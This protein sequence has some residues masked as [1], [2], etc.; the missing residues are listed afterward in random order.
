MPAKT[1]I[2]SLKSTFARHGI[3]K[4]LYTESGPQFTACEFKD[5][6]KEWGFEHKITSPKHRQ[7]NGV[8]ERHIQTLKRILKKIIQENKDN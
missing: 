8:A 7:A 3:P 4:V 2:E 6:I 1:T 5:F